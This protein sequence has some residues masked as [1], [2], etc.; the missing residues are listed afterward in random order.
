MRQESNFKLLD[1][2]EEYSDF[3]RADILDLSDVLD[4][5]IYIRYLKQIFR[6]I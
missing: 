4:Y 6:I 1:I 3:N 2:I 5:W